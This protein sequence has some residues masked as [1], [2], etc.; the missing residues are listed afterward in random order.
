MKKAVLFVHGLAGGMDTWGAFKSLI[1]GED[2]LDYDPFF[3]VYPS[4]LLRIFSLFQSKYGD[5]RAL[6]NGLKTY[7]D[8]TLDKYDEIVLVAHSLGGLIVRQYLLGQKITSKKTK[9]KK[10]IF[11]AVPQ[12]G[13]EL[14]KVA[15]LI[16]F[17]HRHLK[18]LCNNSQFLDALNDLW[19]TTKIENDYE[20]KIILATE[21]KVQ[22]VTSDT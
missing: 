13:T 14:A 7:I 9:T 12:E 18:Q 17:G 16:S 2:E 20:F 4:A 21:D 1:E 8:Y 15:S 6:S 10:V 3:Y 19:A 5:I 22:K 11:Y